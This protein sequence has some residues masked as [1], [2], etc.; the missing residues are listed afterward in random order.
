MPSDK[1]DSFQ[2]GPFEV[3]RNPD[4]RQFVE[5]LNRLREAVDQCR[6]Q[7]GVG[8]AV[9]RSSGGTV[10]SIKTGGGSAEAPIRHPWKVELGTD[11]SGYFF[12]V[13]KQSFLSS[14][15]GGV[16]PVSG[17]GGKISL[18]VNKLDTTYL[19]VLRVSVSGIN[20]TDATIE[21][22]AQ[23]DFPGLIFPQDGPQTVS[24]TILASASKDGVVQNVTKNLTL[25]LANN[26][27]FAAVVAV[28]DVG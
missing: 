11:A 26:A 27:G 15:P 5:K 19:C 10:L 13:E 22:V 14:G 23:S 24:R 25:V 21:S 12:R 1:A 3:S 18:G 6:V 8:Y 28:Q 17:L 9:N 2:C 4:V 7:P 16:L 20:A